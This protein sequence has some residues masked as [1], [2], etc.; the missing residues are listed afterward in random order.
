M[1]APPSRSFLAASGVW[2]SAVG[3]AT[4]QVLSVQTDNAY[5]WLLVLALLAP[6]GVLFLAGAGAPAAPRLWLSRAGSWLLWVVGAIAAPL[7]G[8]GL[9]TLLF[10]G[11]MA[12]GPLISY[13]LAFVGLLATLY[14]V[15]FR[16]L[17]T[18]RQTAA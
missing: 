16:P 12:L 8:L 3:V 10:Q 6:I 5:L 17:Q 7:L 9:A 2:L 15:A 18:P 14:F 13:A 1:A 4:P 11:T